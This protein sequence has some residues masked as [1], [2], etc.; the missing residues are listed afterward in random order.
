MVLEFSQRWH[1]QL[2]ERIK[3]R[4][5][6]ILRLTIALNLALLLLGPKVPEFKNNNRR[7]RKSIPF[8]SCND[9]R[10]KNRKNYGIKE[11]S[12]NCVNQEK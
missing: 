3:G 11:S 7:I 4:H 6:P 9:Q 12:N 1:L 10:F 5:K 2:K 8:F